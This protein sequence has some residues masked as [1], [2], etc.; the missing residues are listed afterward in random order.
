MK[1][2]EIIIVLLLSLFLY[3]G[4]SKKETKKAKTVYIKTTTL[5]KNIQY[6]VKTFPGITDATNK[7]TLSFN[8]PGKIINIDVKAGQKIQKG[9]VI[10][11]LSTSYYKPLSVITDTFLFDADKSLARAKKLVV[12]RALAPITYD[13]FLAWREIAESLKDICHTILND[14]I[15]Y[16]PFTGY[17]DKKYVDCF[18]AV[19]PGTPVVGLLDCSSI[20]IM[21]NLSEKVISLKKQMKEFTCS[22]SLYP[23]KTF[24]AKIKEIGIKPNPKTN[25]YPAKI[26]VENLDKISINPGMTAYV[27]IKIDLKNNKN[28]FD[29]PINSISSDIYNTPILW[30]YN[31]KNST[32]SKFHVKLLGLSSKD[33][34]ISGK[35]FNPGDMIVTEGCHFLRDGLPVKLSPQSS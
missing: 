24:K 8:I 1:A 20:D 29:V 35:N 32:V 2:K 22:F 23:G 6:E 12:T 19:L 34:R 14:T 9:D 7:T 33:I 28:V 11:T 21:F 18:D 5:K 15:L 10:G 26:T 30:K 27:H 16:A 13:Q 3:A 4:C 31:S 25:T 17:I